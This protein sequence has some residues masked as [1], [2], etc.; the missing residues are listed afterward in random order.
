MKILL[1]VLAFV[2]GIL[3]GHFLFPARAKG[4]WVTSVNGVVINDPSISVRPCTNSK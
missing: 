4:H 1:V 2:A 3:V